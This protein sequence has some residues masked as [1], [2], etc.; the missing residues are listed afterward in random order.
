MK[1]IAYL[2]GKLFVLYLQML[3]FFS[4]D[5]TALKIFCLFCVRSHNFRPSYYRLGIILQQRLHLNCILAMT[6]TASKRTIDTIMD[7]LSIP[8]TNKIQTS[9]VRKNLLCTASRSTTRC[10]LSFI[11]FWLS[12]ADPYLCSQNYANFLNFVDTKIFF[13]F[14]SHLHSKMQEALLFTVI[15]RWYIMFF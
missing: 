9:P 10:N 6:A 13:R 14:F 12:P 5:K 2:N 1:H 4:P 7:S 15:F 8:H 11:F 3:F